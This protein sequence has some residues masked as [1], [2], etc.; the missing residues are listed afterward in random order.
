MVL[1]HVRYPRKS[2]LNIFLAGGELHELLALADGLVTEAARRLG[3]DAISLN[4]R[5]GWKRVLA[6]TGWGDQGVTLGKEVGR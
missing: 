6:S 5:P 2:V 4:G 3:C 1:E